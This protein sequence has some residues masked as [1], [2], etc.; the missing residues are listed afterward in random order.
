MREVCAACDRLVYSVVAVCPRGR[1][2]LC[3]ER[4]FGAVV[5]QGYELH[6]DVVDLVE[7]CHSRPDLFIHCACVRDDVLKYYIP[8]LIQVVAQ[9]LCAQCVGGV[10]NQSISWHYV[11][12]ALSPVNGGV[13]PQQRVQRIGRWKLTLGVISREICWPHGTC[14]LLLHCHKTLLVEAQA[15]AQRCFTLNEGE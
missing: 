12:G 3:Q 5:V 9:T 1:H 6:K 8:A 10:L 15:C 4:C 13:S 7:P 14:S 11:G 2:V